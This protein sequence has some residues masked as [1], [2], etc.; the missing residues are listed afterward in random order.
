[1]AYEIIQIHRF[2]VASKWQLDA[3][4]LQTRWTDVKGHRDVKWWLFY[5]IPVMWHPWIQSCTKPNP[6]TSCFSKYLFYF[7]NQQPC[8]TSCFSRR[9]QQ[10]SISRATQQL[11]FFSPSNLSPVHL[12]PTHNNRVCCQ[13]C[14]SHPLHVPL[15]SRSLF[16]TRPHY[17]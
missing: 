14:S 12:G 2:T 1:M 8:A 13:Y 4:P 16:L 6:T 5:D 10:V 9:T 3:T 7:D 11:L 15:A 17:L